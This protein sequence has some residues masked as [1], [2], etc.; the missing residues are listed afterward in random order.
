M[1][2]LKEIKAKLDAIAE[3]QGRLLARLDE[4]DEWARKIHAEAKAEY[5]RILAELEPRPR[6]VKRGAK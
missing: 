6:K 5:E 4:H 2:S 1:T 3:S